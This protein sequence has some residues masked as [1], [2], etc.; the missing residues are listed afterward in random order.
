MVD[1]E[2]ITF[3]LAIFVLS[4]IGFFAIPGAQDLW[5]FQ[6]GQ[7]FKGEIW[8]IITFNFVHLDIL[9][10][11]GNIIALLITTLLAME[12][13]MKSQYFIMLFFV[14]SIVLALVEG[15]FFPFLVIAGA[16]LGI[17][18]M[19][20]GVSVEGRRL[21]PI[22]VFV[23]LVILSILLNQFFNDTSTIIQGLFHFFGFL[24]GILLYYGTVKYINKRRPILSST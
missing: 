7:F 14:S 24:S 17:Y 11:I 5:S 21:I 2:I 10:L 20:G 15:I 8:R 6:G 13:E 22:Y 19:L 9:H 4:V 18:S 3:S 12:I 23:P 1:S 16:S